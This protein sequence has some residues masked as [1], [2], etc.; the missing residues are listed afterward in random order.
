MGPLLWSWSCMS[1]LFA[2]YQN[3]FFYLRYVVA[4]H[5]S[6]GG[7]A[8]GAGLKK[9][10]NE[11]YTDENA[12][13]A[14]CIRWKLRFKQLYKHAVMFILQKLSGNPVPFSCSNP[15]SASD[16]EHHLPT[17]F[18][19]ERSRPSLALHQTSHIAFFTP[20]HQLLFLLFGSWDLYVVG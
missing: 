14:L 6:L 4:S 3:Q 2:T 19:L 9:V 8:S 12:M 11:I 10:Q 13:V 18:E 17:C 15:F 7:Q 1:T 20:K 16:I 5:K